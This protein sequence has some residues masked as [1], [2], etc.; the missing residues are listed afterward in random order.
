MRSSTRGMML[1]AALLVASGAAL[2][3]ARDERPAKQ[4]DP[5][6][7]AKNQQKAARRAARARKG[8]H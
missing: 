1:A 4:P 3:P 5:T 2:P 8:G 6:K 7:L